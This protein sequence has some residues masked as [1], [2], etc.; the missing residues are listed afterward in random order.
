MPTAWWTTLNISPI[1]LASSPAFSSANS[2]SVNNHKWDFCEL[3]L[4]ALAC[5]LLYPDI[6]GSYFGT[7]FPHLFLMTY[8]HLRPQKPSQQYTPR[9]FGF[10][11]HKP[12][13]QSCTFS[14][15]TFHLGFR[16]STVAFKYCG[17]LM[18]EF[19]SL[20]LAVNCCEICICF[21]ILLFCNLG[22][23]S[24]SHLI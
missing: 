22:S 4:L 19:A 23:L 17:L 15:S 7:T 18:Y 1:I 6:D 8:P 3:R 13:W 16:E 10:K 14:S 9:V 21:L 11:L 5:P 2:F 20:G 24:L 12:S